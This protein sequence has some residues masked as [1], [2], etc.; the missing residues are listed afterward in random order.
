MLMN[1]TSKEA[2]IHHISSLRRMKIQGR[3]D[4]TFRLCEGL[5]LTVESGIRHRHP[6]YDERQVR[7]ARM[8]L[9][10]GPSLVA[11]CFPGA[12]VAP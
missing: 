8:R 5:R 3:I 11:R 6:D 7:L 1:D 12:D 10:M 2:R 4:L 9:S